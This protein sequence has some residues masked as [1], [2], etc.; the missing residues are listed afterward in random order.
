MCTCGHRQSLEKYF[1]QIL[2]IYLCIAYKCNLLTVRRPGWNINDSLSSVYIGYSSCDTSACRHNAQIYSLVERMRQRINFFWIRFIYDPFPV[3]RKMR[4]PVVI[5]IKC[6]LFL[7][8]SI[9]SHSPY[10]HCSCPDCI[11]IDPLSI[12]AIF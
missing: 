2:L 11:E 9:W 8:C 10:L 7:F 3:R 1:W 12:R 6:N 4:K 5:L